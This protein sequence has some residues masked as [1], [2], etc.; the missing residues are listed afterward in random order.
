MKKIN[1]RYLAFRRDLELM[2]AEP[3]D[4]CLRSVCGIYREYFRG[5]KE[6]FLPY[7]FQF[8][9]G[10]YPYYGRSIQPRNQFDSSCMQP[11]N[12]AICKELE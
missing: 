2:G 6:R 4:R 8:P 9:V 11:Y 5:K 10:F 3:G 12:I 1:K 7:G